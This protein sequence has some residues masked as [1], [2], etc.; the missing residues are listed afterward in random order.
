MGMKARVQTKRIEGNAER[1][2]LTPQEQHA[3]RCVLMGISRVDAAKSMGVFLKTYDSHRLSMMGKF[4]AK[5]NV[6]LVHKVGGQHVT[7]ALRAKFAKYA[8][9]A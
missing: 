7:N 9:V 1:V 4:G 5:N 3:M 6:D 8:P 2:R